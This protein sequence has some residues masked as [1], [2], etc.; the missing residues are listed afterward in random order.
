LVDSNYDDF[1][2]KAANDL[3][4]KY[5]IESQEYLLCDFYG[6]DIDLF[7][8]KLVS[9]L[10][11]NTYL[12]KLYQFEIEEN[13]DNSATH[14]A[15]LSGIWIPTGDAA[16]LGIH[17]IIGLQAGSN[18]GKLSY[19]FTLSFRFLNTPNY[20]YARSKNSGNMA[21]TNH[22]FGGYIGLDFRWDLLEKTHN[23]LSLLSGFGYDGFDAL[24]EDNSKGI[25]SESV[26]STN[27]NFGIGYRSFYSAYAYW[28]IDLKFNI[29]NYRMNKVVDITGNTITINLVWGGLVPSNNTNWIRDLEYRE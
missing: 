15:F 28:G 3:K 22:Y 17:P 11:N 6:G 7:F 29:V 8:T 10:Y 23:T 16:Q 13:K 20:Y 25:K 4:S 21:L 12:Y 5:P 24:V 9:G 2:Q 1:T 19:D 27:F 14:A 18:N 26:G